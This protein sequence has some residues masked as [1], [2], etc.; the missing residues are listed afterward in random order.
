MEIEEDDIGMSEL[1]DL[2]NRKKLIEEL[3]VIVEEN[4]MGSVKEVKSITK[5]KSVKHSKK[6]SIGSDTSSS[7]DSSVRSKKKKGS[8][9][10]QN[11]S[12]KK[13]KIE[14]LYKLTSVISKTNGRFQT[15]VTMD[16][17]LE[18]IQMEFTRIKT[19]ID[20]ESMLKFCKHGLVMGIKGVEMLNNNYDPFGIDLDGWGESISYNMATNEYD[21]VL[22]E[23]CE[24][25]KGVGKISPELKLL[26]MI[27]MS[28]VMFS[29]TKRAAK[30][31]SSL[32]SI[33]NSLRTQPSKPSPPK[34]SIETPPS[35]PDIQPPRFEP[36]DITNIMEKLRKNNDE[37]IIID[38]AKPKRGRPPKKT[39]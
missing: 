31:P 35:S 18:E 23:L 36:T 38:T 14:L 6:S 17:T 32:N 24:K 7:G 28:G 39:A 26:L 21:E 25:Y 16:N 30:D 4:V 37:K 29:F 34:P 5:I 15:Y 11:E 3:P 2:A 19:I 33:L 27:L 10:N 9:E 8:R 22:L 12:I 13:E 20:N 1:E